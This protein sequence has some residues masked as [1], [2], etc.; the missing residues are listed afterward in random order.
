MNAQ[1]ASRRNFLK[2]ASVAALGFPAIVPASVFGQNAPSNR[3]HLAAFGVGGRGS[4]V[5]G[6]L[7]KQPDARYLG[8]CDAYRTRAERAKKNWDGIYGGDYVKI[9]SNPSDILSRSDIDAVV[10]TTPDHWHAP[11]AIAAARAK[12]DMYVEKPLSVAMRWNF[13]VRDEVRKANRVFQYGTQQRSTQLF[14][15]ACELVRNGYIGKVKHVEAWCHD[16]S[17]QY[18]AFNVPQYGSVRP[19][20][21]P[22]D[23]D[24]DLW[25]GPAP[26]RQYTSD[27]CTSYGT[28]HTHDFSIGFVAGWGAHPLDIAQW[29]LNTDETAPVYYEGAGTVPHV[30]LYRTVDNWDIHCYYGNGVPV[31]FMSERVAKDVITKYRKR[32]AGHGTTFFGDEGWV[33]VDRGGMETSRESLMK[34]GGGANDTPLYVSE[35]HQRNFLDCIRSR[36]PTISPIEAAVRS[37]TI[38]H[39]SDLVVRT[40]APIEYD[41]AAE[42]ISNNPTAAKMMDRPMRSKWAV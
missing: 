14:R 33:S 1:G 21:T 29:G 20:P 3:I 35:H 5:N 40:N 15:R 4:A 11:L 16:M 6:A 10:I 7:A 23:L 30:G 9:Y 25:C 34:A 27:L 18:A 12:K 22:E 2:G 37:D 28:Y 26:L 31:R 41:P 17:Q 8:V 42:R 24:L 32:Y 39:L 38:S 13:R 19:V 36:K